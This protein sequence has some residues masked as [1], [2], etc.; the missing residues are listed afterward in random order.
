VVILT[1]PPAAAAGGLRLY[2]S[3]VGVVGAGSLPVPVDAV[4]AM[5]W[6]DWDAWGEALLS[7]AAPRYLLTKRQLKRVFDL[8]DG[9]GNNGKKGRRLP[10]RP[11]AAP[12]PR[13]PTVTL[14]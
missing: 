8:A 5:A 3:R 9:S 4:R 2:G 6:N 14:P 1:A 12:L 10:A 11:P 7:S 13:M